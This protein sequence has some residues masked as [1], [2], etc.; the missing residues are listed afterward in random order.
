M[1]GLPYQLARRGYQDYTSWANYLYRSQWDD[2]DAT[3]M[4]AGEIITA[5]MHAL[6]L[7]NPSEQTSATIAA[8]IAVATY[9]HHVDK[10]S[11]RD[12]N[13]IFLTFKAQS[14]FQRAPRM[15]RL[16][17]QPQQ[18]A[19]IRISQGGYRGMGGIPQARIKLLAGPRDVREQLIE[20]LP[21]TPAGLLRDQP[22][23]ARAIFSAERLPVSCP[24]PAAA[25]MLAKAKINMRGAVASLG[26]SLMRNSLRVVAAECGYNRAHR[27]CM[28]AHLQHAP[29]RSV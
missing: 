20:V 29:L 19:R 16:R 15:R 10:L 6:L 7:K 9:G 11:S 2:I 26:G 1:A 4:A 12:M 25:V 17:L 24:L 14:Q 13:T 22:L 21:P 5:Q 23:L 18:V 28:H 3:P 27:A 8:G